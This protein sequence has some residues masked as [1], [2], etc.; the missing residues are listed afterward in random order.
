MSDKFGDG[1]D[2]YLYPGLNV[3]RNRWGFIRR[4]ALRRRLMNSRAAC[5]DARI[6]AALRGCRIC[7]LFT[8]SSIRIFLTGRDLR[9]VDIYQGD[10]RFAISPTSRK[11]AMR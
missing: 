6:G 1:R 10:T 8:V 3:M 9:E 4:S 11:R 5:G 7:A 2:P